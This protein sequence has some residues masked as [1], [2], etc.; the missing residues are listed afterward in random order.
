MD[1]KEQLDYCRVKKIFDKGFGFL[2]S[3]HYDGYV[4]FHFNMV[5]DKAVKEKLEKMKRGD[6]YF[7]F[8]STLK[9]GKR[10]VSRLW[11]DISA[12]DKELLPGFADRITGEFISGATNPYEVAYVTKQLRENEYLNDGNLRMLLSSDKLL[13][14]PSILKA[15]LRESE[16]GKL[17]NAESLIEQLELKRIEKDEWVEKVFALLT[18]ETSNKYPENKFTM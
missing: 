3:L 7:Y 17:S 11:L 8:I 12:V 9:D 6:I 15:F 1:I 13:K 16:A 10:K 5:K 14:N 4:F 18:S 2:T